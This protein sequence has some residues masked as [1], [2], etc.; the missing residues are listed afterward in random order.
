MN[1]NII[2]TTPQNSTSVI[3]GGGRM[4]SSQLP[5]A[6]PGTEEPDAIPWDIPR[7]IPFPCSSS[8]TSS[9]N[10]SSQLVSMLCPPTPKDSRWIS[11]LRPSKLS[12][13]PSE[14]KLDTELMS[15]EELFDFTLDS[16]K[17]LKIDID[18]LEKIFRQQRFLDEVMENSKIQK[19]TFAEYGE[20]KIFDVIMKD[21]FYHKGYYATDEEV[22]QM[23]MSVLQKL[24]KELIVLEVNLGRRRKINHQFQIRNYLERLHIQDDKQRAKREAQLKAQKEDRFKQMRDEYFQQLREHQK[25]QLHNHLRDQQE[26]EIRIH[27]QQDKLNDIP[28]N[29]S[30]DNQEE[31]DS[32]KSDNV[33]LVRKSQSLPKDDANHEFQILVSKENRDPKPHSTGSLESWQTPEVQEVLTRKPGN[34]FSAFSKN[35]EELHPS[36]GCP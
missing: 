35:K 2:R 4:A 36:S 22:S 17:K 32:V 8:T 28:L 30:E 12:Q 1:N 23:Y 13:K 20:Q 26:E 25:E 9:E 31:I 16:V 14:V 7:P 15:G 6:N 3:I 27:L 33:F 29:S 11:V 24:K 10:K 19:Q 34:S 21:P 5:T 18:I